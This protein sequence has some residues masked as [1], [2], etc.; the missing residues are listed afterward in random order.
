MKKILILIIPTLF[1]SVF[2]NGNGDKG[3]NEIIEPLSLYT[4]C[5]EGEN[6]DPQPMLSGGVQDDLG[7]DVYHACV[8]IQTTLGVQVAIIG[9]DSSG[10]YFF[11][12]VSN[13]SYNLVINA[14]GFSPKV[15]PFSV[16]G[17]AQTINVVL[18]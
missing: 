15:T 14:S 1:S 16:I 17:T 6:E 10:H 4:S 8:E 2:F 18:E 12:S 3:V 13:G 5:D 11:N 7:N 9:T